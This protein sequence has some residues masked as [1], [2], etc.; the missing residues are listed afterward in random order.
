M[1]TSASTSV[2]APL[3]L[4]PQAL[5]LGKEN[6]YLSV[7]LVFSRSPTDLRPSRD[8]GTLATVAAARFCCFSAHVF[9]MAWATGTA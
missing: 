9:K 4:T 1:N 5:P 3:S 2:P 6:T 7:V 8:H